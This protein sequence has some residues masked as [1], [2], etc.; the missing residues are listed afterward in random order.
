M[1]NFGYALVLAAVL[2]NVLGQIGFKHIATQIKGRNLAELIN[3]PLITTT[4]F[5]GLAYGLAMILWVIALTKVPLS[6]SYSIFA[7]SFLLVPLA[8][9]LIYGEDT[10]I[11]GVVISFGLIVLALFILNTLK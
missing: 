11:W 4:I 3:L 6:K 10:N 2:L 7:L 5:V 8:G 1:F 9:V